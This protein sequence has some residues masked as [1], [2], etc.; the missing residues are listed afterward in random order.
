LNDVVRDA[1]GV[2]YEVRANLPR[3]AAWER[4]LWLESKDDAQGTY[5][6]AVS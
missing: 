1:D 2:V 3:R 5:V 4:V 6:M